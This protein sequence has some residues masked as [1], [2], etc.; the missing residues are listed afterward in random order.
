MRLIG[1]CGRSGSGK[2]EFSKIAQNEGIKTVD[3]DAVYKE[4]VSKPSPCLWELAQE[5]GDEIVKD[6]ALNR[7]V[8][9]PIVFSDK[10]K[11]KRL[12]E[13]ASKHILLKLDEIFSSCGENE[14]L[15][16]DAPTLFENGLEKR[17]NVVVAVLASDEIAAERI[18]KRDGITKEEALL[19]LSN[20]PSFDFFETHC[21]HIIYN[22]STYDDFASSAKQL[23]LKLKEELL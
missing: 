15:I 5:F 23:I 14:L 18:T 10:D 4:I 12:N 11:L 19:R 17:C 3:C 22:N 20:Q 7:R 1:L 8:L 13:I 21:D 9:A 6:G 2:G 16:L